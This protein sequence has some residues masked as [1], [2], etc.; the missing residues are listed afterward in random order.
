MI[1]R[2]ALLLQGPAVAVTPAEVNQVREEALRP[3][4]VVSDPAAFAALRGEWAALMA[5][6]DAGAFNAWEWLYPWFR[7][8]GADREL[9]LL[10]VRDAEGKLAGLMPLGI[11]KVR[12]GPAKL[13]RLSFLGETHVGSDYL[14]V[15]ARRGLERQVACAFGRRILEDQAAWDVLDLVD[16]S[17]SSVTIEVLAE[18]FRGAGYDFQLRERYLCPFEPLS[19]EP[20]DAFLKRTGRRDNFLRRKKWLEKQPG[21]QFE[22]VTDPAKLSRPLADFFRLH[23]L[24][25]EGDG[26]SQ[27]IKGPSVEAFHRDATALLAEAGKLRMYTLRLG[28]KALASVYG[29]VHGG[30]FLYFQSG[31]DPEWRNKSVGLVLVGET[32]REALEEGVTEYDFLRGTEGYKADWTSQRRQTLAVR[33]FKTGS[34]GSWLDKR[35]KAA[36]SFRDF[37]KKVLPTNAVEKLRRLRRKRAQI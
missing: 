9:R 22:K 15:V 12:V 32:F 29:I 28:D 30:K 37:V 10:L 17:A 7:R 34:R 26:G 18:L 1:S 36:K 20:F 21:Y 16:F 5:Q 23:A 14:D 2:E 4:E 13:R 25:W 19:A 24:R 6:S 8:I 3:A 11:E 27:G 31:Y 35:E 33:V